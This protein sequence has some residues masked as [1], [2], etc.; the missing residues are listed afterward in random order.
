M[1][2]FTLDARK[3]LTPVFQAVLFSSVSPTEFSFLERLNEN[4]KV[5]VYI[6]SFQ[7]KR[8]CSLIETWNAFQHKGYKLIS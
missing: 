5:Y 6:L 2:I 7:R 1:K 8:R 3:F 4:V